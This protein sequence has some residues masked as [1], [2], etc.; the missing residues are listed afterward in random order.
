MALGGGLDVPTEQIAVSPQAIGFQI[1]VFGQEGKKSFFF[2]C[3]FVLHA[4]DTHT[5]ILVTNTVFASAAS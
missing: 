4:A 2:I 1:A 5:N 3:L